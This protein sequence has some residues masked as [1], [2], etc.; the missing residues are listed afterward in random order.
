MSSRQEEKER[1]RAEREAREHAEARKASGRRRL[2]LV[3]AAVLGIAAVAAIIAAI[4]SAT[5]GGG[6]ST[7]SANNNLADVPIPAR[8]VYDLDAAAKAAG[9]TW[10]QHKD[11][12][13]EHIADTATFKGY[14]TNPP[15]SGTHRI[16]PADDGIYPPDAPPS[17]NATVHSLEHGRID[18]QYKPGTTP[19]R[20]GQLQTLVNE[21]VKGVPGFHELLFKNTTKMPYAV[22]A[23]S[24]TR[25]ITCPEWN[26]QVF[27]AIRAFRDK[28]VD[29][30]REVVM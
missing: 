26:D 14:K 23:T 30:G 24:W 20:I 16:T 11:E 9:C 22:A 27:D 19:R 25:S 4:V 13:H 7:A 2:Q 3:G 8:K 28:W 29:H 18:I 10:K 21:K 1:R 12:G 15:T 5:G 6:D 17:V